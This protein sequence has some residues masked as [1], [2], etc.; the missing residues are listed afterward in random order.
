MSRDTKMTSGVALLREILDSC[1][2]TERKVA[3]FLLAEPRTAVFCTVAELARRAETSPPAVVRLCKRA[4]L[5]GYRE[6][7]LLL[8][9]DL[10]SGTES[11]EVGPAFELDSGQSVETIARNT[12]DRSK[13]ALDRVLALL[14]PQ[15][16]EETAAAIAAARSV[17]VFGL[18]ASGLVAYDLAIKLSRLGI[19][20]T[21][22]FDS[23]VQIASACGLD[24]RDVAVAI[25]YSGRTSSVVQAA[26]EAKQSG[27]RVAAITCL[28]ASPL[29][30][31][32]DILLAIPTTEP[33][34]RQGASLSRS[35]QLVVVDIL[36]GVLVS[37][38]IERA[39]PLIERSMR[40]THGSPS[41]RSGQ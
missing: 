9:R 21:F 15:A 31:L 6:L 11:G 41:D 8:A 5:S 22:S 7:Q 26:E 39:I 20:C 37:R 17:L 32:T 27:A 16:I 28:G 34:F 13:E 1:A 35:T 33:I 38:N 18:G 10:Y 40:A 25:S 36:Y 24:S 19:P 14:N 29:A 4:G 12:V 3:E 23:H 30:R 2:G